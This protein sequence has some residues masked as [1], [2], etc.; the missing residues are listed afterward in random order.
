M[1]I[2]KED[3][4]HALTEAFRDSGTTTFDTKDIDKALL[5]FEGQIK[6]NT[7]TMGGLLAEMVTGKKQYKDLSNVIE[8]INEQ[9][10][11]FG[12]ELEEEQ[13]VLRNTLLEQK[14]Q[15]EQT[16]LLNAVQ[17]NAINGL[18]GFTKVV[19]GIGSIAGRTL[20]N[21]ASSVQSGSSAFSAAGGL[22]EGA[23]D[24]VHTGVNATA[25]AIGALGTTAML[26]TNPAVKGLGIAATVASP[27]LSGLGDA[28]SAASKAIGGY[29]LKEVEGFVQAFD[30]ISKTGALF[31]N[32][33]QGMFDAAQDAGLTVKQFSEVIKNNS[34]NIARSGMSLSEGSQFVGKV[35]RNGGDEM[36]RR[37]LNLGYSFEEQAALVTDVM[38]DLTVNRGPL[39]A[40][41]AQVREQTEKYA[42][43]LRVIADITG[44]DAKKKLEEARAI[45]EGI[46]FQRNLVR[47]FAGQEDSAIKMQNATLALSNMDPVRQKMFQDLVNYQTMVHEETAQVYTS[48]QG[49]ANSVVDMYQTLKEGKLDDVKAREI[50]AKYRDQIQKELLTNTNIGAII[51]AGGT[52]LKN[53]ATNLTASFQ[54]IF[55]WN[56]KHTPE[57]IKAAEEA[58]K[59]QKTT[60]DA[61]TQNT[62]SAA[63]QMQHFAEDLQNLTE[64]NL[65]SIALIT[66]EII[67]SLADQ[68][69][70]LKKDMTEE[71][72]YKALARNALKA[73]GAGV[74]F[75]GVGGAGVAASVLTGGV[76]TPAAIAGTAAATA[77]GY[78]LGGVAADY[79]L[80]KQPTGAPGAGG[81]ATSLVPHAVGPVNGVTPV[82]PDGLK[83]NGA[84]GTG[85]ITPEL[86]G[87]INAL[88]Q[89]PMFAGATITALNDSASFGP[90]AVP[91]DAHGLGRGIDFVLPNY[92][93]K[94]SHDYV[95]ILKSMG[96]K[97][98]MDEYKF[99]SEN[100]K[101]GGHIHAALKDGGIVNPQS[102]GV[103]A[104]VAEGGQ[105]E[106]V[107][108]LVNGMLP[109]MQALLDK[110]DEMIDI[111]D[112]HKDIS[113]NHLRA[114]M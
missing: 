88:S 106:L 59:H 6:R 37:L 109:G 39:K 57:S 113:E 92:D 68:L 97:K 30:A 12:D 99:P 108:P 25:G 42:E 29:M 31:A 52:D 83:T 13:I 48:S 102:D 49:I 100:A 84:Q 19:S 87:M 112:A 85:Q 82:I 36:R 79:L 101:G 44:E 89:N 21:F 55:D 11:E 27:L 58:A 107:T 81:P 114:V 91:G 62:T 93:P 111:L 33:M 1:D 73:V 70:L 14:K 75:A 35:L 38:R 9:L 10:E 60:D 72:W 61:L 66:A 23:V 50:D 15:A 26:S 94:K 3:L 5:H 20:G 67:D 18:V 63:L 16:R 110:F 4:K 28:A 104:K 41:D 40:T 65:S 78:Q 51:Q 24:I 43:N 69:H 54:T 56:K 86:Q 45:A 64:G 53:S 76:A 2:S 32:G 105:R 103:T 17:Q 90:H 46:Q 80:G 74:G 96:F 47:L 71:P 98:A 34:D 95:D 22:F 8:S 7:N 77:G